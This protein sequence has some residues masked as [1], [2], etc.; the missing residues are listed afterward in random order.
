MP[1]KRKLIER[2]I[3]TDTILLILIFWSKVGGPKQE[4]KMKPN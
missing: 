3:F 2:Q 4:Q 1:Y